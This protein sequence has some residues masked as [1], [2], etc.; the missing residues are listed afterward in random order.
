LDGGGECRVVD[1]RAVD[2]N[3]AREL[4]K[5]EVG[6]AVVDEVGEHREGE[7]TEVLVPGDGVAR[8]DVLVEKSVDL[9]EE[10]GTEVGLENVAS[11]DDEI[12]RERR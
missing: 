2:V 11:S 4:G 10:G 8:K 6:A 5:G 9:G 1:V 3:D 12:L 7:G